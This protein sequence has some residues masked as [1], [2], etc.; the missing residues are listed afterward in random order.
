ME[1]A[2]REQ[3]RA[4][5]G[6]QWLSTG[7]ATMLGIGVVV[8][9]L[10]IE[11]FGFR[12][13]SGLGPTLHFDIVTYHWKGNGREQLFLYLGLVTAVG[14]FGLLRQIVAVPTRN[15]APE[16]VLSVPA[17]AALT[18]AA[19]G[20]GLLRTLLAILI[21]VF[22]LRQR[23]R[24]ADGAFSSL[25]LILLGAWVALFA[26]LPLFRASLQ[27]DSPTDFVYQQEHYATNVLPALDV[28]TGAYRETPKGHMSF[29]LGLIG[30]S[31][32]M[33]TGAEISIV[34]LVAIGHVLAVVVALVTGWVLGRRSAAPL[35]ALTLAAVPL[36]AFTVG[37]AWGTPNLTGQRYLPALAVLLV[38]AVHAHRR[39]H[40]VRL[41][42]AVAGLAL[43]TSTEVGALALAAAAV[44]LLLQTGEGTPVEAVKI[45]GRFIGSVL[46]GAILVRGVVALR[47][48]TFAGNTSSAAAW[49]SGFGGATMQLHPIAA[50]LV[51]VTLGT[52]IWMLALERPLAPRAALAAGI[53]A[54]AAIQWVVFA[55]RTHV[56]NVWFAVLLLGLAVMA[57]AGLES[58]EDMPVRERNRYRPASAILVVALS[59]MAVV[60]PMPG[61]P[62]VRAL[63][64]SREPVYGFCLEGSD[65][66]AVLAAVDELEGFSRADTAV[67]S[68]MPAV[69]RSMGFNADL[70]H[71]RGVFRTDIPTGVQLA[72]RELEERGVRRVIVQAPDSTLGSVSPGSTSAFLEIVEGVE[73]FRLVR[74]S[75]N[76]LVFE[77]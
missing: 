30:R 31:V 49:L 57:L 15:L 66:D 40:N 22:L 36:N 68:S 18:W 21:G 59:V 3:R 20:I 19:L 50:I 65:G 71:N 45:L 72:S 25:A 46:I 17:C 70:V 14:A 39:W 34:R 74:E 67:L 63:D 6:R 64:C 53:L 8:G 5:S 26:V 69:S 24:A 58:D 75:A 1:G 12:S 38:L 32:S 61:L 42:G 29:F 28:F 43:G 23:R 9:V 2:V 37:Y 13:P 54:A 77:R 60:P 76:W 35:L 47:S 16:W 41:L 7:L 73:G 27:W 48:G 11:W 10:F 55:N 4:Q 44:Y 33:L 52:L 62:D 51:L 56:S